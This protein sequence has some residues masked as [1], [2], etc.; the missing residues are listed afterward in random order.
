MHAFML[1]RI[2]LEM[3]SAVDIAHQYQIDQVDSNIMEG[4]VI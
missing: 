4:D 1:K 2:T 3:F